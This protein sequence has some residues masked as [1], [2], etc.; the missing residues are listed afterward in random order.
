MLLLTVPGT[1]SDSHADKDTQWGNKKVEEWTWSLV[2]IS[3]LAHNFGIFFYAECALPFRMTQDPSLVKSLGSSEYLLH[4]LSFI[5]L[6]YIG[7][8]VHC[9]KVLWERSLSRPC[10]ELCSKIT[11]WEKVSVWEDLWHQITVI[12]TQGI[13]KC[14]NSWKQAKIIQNG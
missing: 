11:L 8:T 3:V 4:I 12:S 9:R 7:R 6:W 1:E 14:H 13:E 2:V 5:N 10:L